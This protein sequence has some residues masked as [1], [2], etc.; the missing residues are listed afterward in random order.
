MNSVVKKVNVC[1][2]FIA[3]LP[4]A[5][6]PIL[7]IIG[8]VVGYMFTPFVVPYTATMCCMAIRLRAKGDCFSGLWVSMIQASF[9]IGFVLMIIVGIEGYVFGQWTLIPI[10]S[11]AVI[12]IVVSFAYQTYLMSSSARNTTTT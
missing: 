1:G 5:L 3:V 8:G 2:W 6:I 4:L 12:Y 9:H 11:S 10:L 7:V